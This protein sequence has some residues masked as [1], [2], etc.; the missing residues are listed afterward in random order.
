MDMRKSN[1]KF[2]PSSSSTKPEKAAASGKFTLF[3]DDDWSAV[4]L[5][6]EKGHNSNSS[7]STKPNSNSQT[8]K[9]TSSLRVHKASSI[10]K[11]QSFEAQS[12]VSSDEKK[13]ESTLLK[14]RLI[15]ALPSSSSMTVN[16]PARVEQS[17]A[18]YGL[19]QSTDLH[20]AIDKGGIEVVSDAVLPT[21]KGKVA[22]DAHIVDIEDEEPVSPDNKTMSTATVVDVSDVAEV[23]AEDATHT[24]DADAIDATAVSSEDTLDAAHTI[25][26]IPTHSTDTLYK[27]PASAKSTAESATASKYTAKAGRIVDVELEDEQPEVE[28]SESEQSPQPLKSS[29]ASLKMPA[30]IKQ[31][32]SVSSVVVPPATSLQE[33]DALHHTVQEHTSDPILNRSELDVKE[34]EVLRQ[35]K[36]FNAQQLAAEEEEGLEDYLEDDESEDDAFEGMHL[37]QHHSTDSS[38]DEIEDDD[39]DEKALGTSVKSRA[40]VRSAGNIAAFIRIANQIPMLTPEEEKE[41]AKRYRENGDIEA[42]RRLVTSHL[43]LVVSVAHGYAGYGLPLPDLIQEGNVGLMKAVMHFE[44]EQGRLA[45]FAVHWIR[46]SISDYVIRNWRMV[47]VATTKAQRKLF[48]NLRQLK[49]HLGWFNEQERKKIA[50]SLGVSVA[51]VAEME[52]R[53]AGA[54]IGFDLEED[55]SGGDKNFAVTLSPSSYLEDESSDFAENYEN[56]DYNAWQIRKLKEA[57][58]FLDERSQ[59]IIKRRWLDD[60]KATFQELSNELKV[61][62]ERVR[63][64]ESNAMNK[65]KLSLVNEGVKEDKSVQS[66]PRL[67]VKAAT[68]KTWPLTKTTAESA[69]KDGTAKA[70]AT[71]NSKSTG[72]RA[73]TSKK[74][75]SK[76]SKN[77]KVKAA[78][79]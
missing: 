4:A 2:E 18:E 57:L 11:K 39:L 53:L 62:I 38:E 51:D 34:L 27:S 28:L 75:G 20:D 3:G 8:E 30:L 6:R 26:A 59:Y 40:V 56:V 21:H 71:S 68:N 45:A 22:V 10:S 74:V 44:P 7:P 15:K 41:L 77:S 63:Q 46:A 1:S 5:R 72:K 54:D 32:S 55:D 69:D 49:K 79:K 19:S 12:Q 66:V 52:M 23:Q 33:I 35:I 48:F 76:T 13:Y 47:K 65:I 37:E 60:N 70:S 67:T 16:V 9:K 17:A 42:A 31:T 73:S 43:R 29:A 64:I 78:A 36:E 25:D 61:S 58:S 50:D 24:I 14:R